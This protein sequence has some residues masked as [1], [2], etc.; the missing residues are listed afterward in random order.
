MPRME[1]GGRAIFRRIK[2]KRNPGLFQGQTAHK[3]VPG[4]LLC[5]A[6]RS[7]WAERTNAAAEFCA[8]KQKGPA[9]LPGR[10]S[11]R[12]RDASEL[13]LGVQLCLQV[14]PCLDDLQPEGVAAG[15][16][17][18]A[19]GLHQALFHTPAGS[20]LAVDGFCADTRF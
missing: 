17:A 4:F 3:R 2:R 16:E 5:G 11:L 14:V 15:F 13:L 10:A 19:I 7:Q 9:G 1:R 8:E 20:L 12:F 18:C 6:G